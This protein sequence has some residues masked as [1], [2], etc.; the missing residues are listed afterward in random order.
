MDVVTADRLQFAF[1]IMFHYLFPITTIGLA[2]FVALY[3]IQAA[4]GDADAARAAAFWT[5]IFTINFAIGVVTGIPMEFQFGTNWATFSATAGAVVGQ[6]LAMEGVYAFFLESVFLGVLLYGKDRVAPTLYSAAAVVVWIGSWLSGFFIVAT[7]AWMQHPV[8]YAIVGKK[9][10]LTSLPA[11]LFS[12][13]AWWQYLHVI[14]GAMVAGGFVVAGVG[15]YYLLS[16]RET[17]LGQRFVKV[18]V[19]VGLVFAVLAVFPSGDIQGDD[20]TAYQPVKLAAMEGLFKT[21]DGAPLAI[22][23]MPDSRTQTLIDPIIVP[24]LLSFLAYGNF[25]ANVKGLSAYAS[26]LW[27]PVDLTYYAYHVMVGLGTIFIGIAV[28]CALFLWRQRLFHTP[29]LLWL[30]LLVMPFPYIASEAGWVTAEVGRQPWV[31]YGLLRTSGAASPTVAGGEIIFTLIGFAG[32][33][34]L[35]GFLFLYLT[36]REIGH[37]PA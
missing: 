29:L 34:F 36:L 17:A 9:I 24:D 15:A 2:P 22:I 14:C 4:R 1:T 6:P 25:R 8:G 19:I 27:P 35:L 7:N 11:L 37:G 31:V 10:E 3:T 16:K 32:V 18:G 13:F 28:L 5:R 23:G 26:D 33:Y 20:V 30:L 21:V 12:P